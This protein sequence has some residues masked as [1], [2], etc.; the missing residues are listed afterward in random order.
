MPID[1]LE[2]FLHPLR[3]PPLTGRY[4]AE[5]AVLGPTMRGLPQL[6]PARCDSSATCVTACPTDA[7]VLTAA[8]WAIDVGR[9]VFCG[10]C[11]AACPQ[12]AIRLGRRFE[13][14]SRTR[15]ALILITPI[16]GP[17]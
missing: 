17:R 10:A 15:E 5:P 9:C 4:P 3:R 2:R 12:D 13:L 7:I 1:I 16:G 8:T 11:E 6:D 14:A